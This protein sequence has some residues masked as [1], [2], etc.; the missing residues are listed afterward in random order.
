MLA[1]LIERRGPWHLLRGEVELNSSGERTHGVEHLA[2][3]LCHGPVRGERSPAAAPVR[4]LHHGRVL[5]QVKRGDERAGAVGCRQRRR[6]PS[7]R[8]QPQRRVLKLWLGR[9]Q[10]RRELAQHLRVGMQRVA[11]LAPILVGKCRP[12]GCHNASRCRPVAIEVVQGTYKAFRDADKRLLTVAKRYSTKV[13]FEKL[14]LLI[15]DELGKNISGTGMDLN[16]IGKWRVSG[17]PQRPD[18]RR[19]VALSLTAPSLGNGLGIGLA[20]FTTERFLKEYD[21]AVTYVNLLTASEPGG[22]GTR[23]GA[24]PL[25]LATDRE[26]IEIALY[27]AVANSSARVCRIQSTSRLDKFWVSE[28][29]LEEVGKNSALQVVGAPGPLDFDPKGNL[30]DLSRIDSEVVT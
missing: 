9:R 11:R 23:E 7:A 1:I 8:C 15:V 18:F 6:L 3:D 17:G 14:D 21:P 20:D 22:M 30:K 27:S 12:P 29:L 19:I 5:V 2:R 13:P 16:V 10:P 28:A 4:V 24:V 26:A 25:A